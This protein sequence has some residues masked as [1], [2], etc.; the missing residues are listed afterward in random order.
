MLDHVSNCHST[1]CTN[2]II[3][4]E[5]TNEHGQ[6]NAQDLSPLPSSFIDGKHADFINDDDVRKVASLIF[7]PFA[8][9]SHL[10]DTWLKSAE[11]FNQ[12]RLRSHHLLN[13]LVYHRHF[14]QTC[15]HQG[16]FLF[17]QL[18]IYRAPFKG[19]HRAL[20]THHAAGTWEA[21][22]RDLAL[23]IGFLTV[24]MILYFLDPTRSI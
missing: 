20:S 5:Y 18:L 2:G 14:I 21:E 1:A 23:M 6:N 17:F 16:D 7:G 12:I 13:I 15:R 19:L 22:C 8:M 11:G 24:G 9:R 3:Q 10:H 4:K